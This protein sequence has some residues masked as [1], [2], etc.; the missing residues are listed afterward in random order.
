MCNHDALCAITVKAPNGTKVYIYDASDNQATSGSV[1]TSKTKTLD[2]VKYDDYTVKLQYGG[3]W[4][5]FT[6]VDAKTTCPKVLDTS[7]LTAKFPGISSV[8]I[9]VKVNDGVAG[10]TTRANVALLS[11]ST[12]FS[13]ADGPDVNATPIAGGVI[14]VTCP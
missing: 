13:D 8:R 2:V 9:Y 3:N 4:Y 1:G 10:T 11:N 12:K 5:Q 6:H 14:P 7:T